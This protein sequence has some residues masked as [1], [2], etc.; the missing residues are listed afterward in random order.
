MI[1]RE[2]RRWEL[3]IDNERVEHHPCLAMKQVSE[4]ATNQASIQPDKQIDNYYLFILFWLYLCNTI[5]R[6][7]IILS[8]SQV[9]VIFFAS[10]FLHHK[11]ILCLYYYLKMCYLLLLLYSSSLLKRLNIQRE[12]NSERGLSS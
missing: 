10:L 5:K 3:V 2:D 8:L 1:E 6:D 4:Q 7:Q 11:K 12:K 9:R